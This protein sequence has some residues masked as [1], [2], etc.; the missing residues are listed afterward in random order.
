MLS[1]INP[2]NITQNNQR[3]TV[4]LNWTRQ[5]PNDSLS[6]CSGS[7]GSSSPTRSS[8]LTDSSSPDPFTD[9]SKSPTGS[10][11]SADH[12]VSLQEAALEAELAMLQHAYSSESGQLNNYHLPVYPSNNDQSDSGS[13]S[14]AGSTSG[15]SSSGSTGNGTGTFPEPQIISGMNSSGHTSIAQGKVRNSFS[16]VFQEKNRDRF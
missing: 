15:T 9:R 13:D 6:S 3:E 11:T 14:G 16:T 4:S 7:T 2:A 1:A 10:K 12:G 5:T 8:S